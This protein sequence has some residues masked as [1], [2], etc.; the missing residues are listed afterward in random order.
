[1]L[2]ANSAIV[3]GLELS[4]YSPARRIAC[5]QETGRK[6]IIEF[7]LRRD[8]YRRGAKLLTTNMEKT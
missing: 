3:H 2:K 7:N 8:L 4:N 1:V 5:L 6:S